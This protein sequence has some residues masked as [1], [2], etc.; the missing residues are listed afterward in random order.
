MK[1]FSP[2]CSGSGSPARGRQ[3]VVITRTPSLGS[4]EH[5]SGPANASNISISASP[6]A[7]G[8]PH[9]IIL[10]QL[11]RLG[12]R[13]GGLQITQGE[14]TDSMLMLHCHDGARG[15]VQEDDGQR[16]NPSTLMNRPA[17]IFFHGGGKREDQVLLQ[18]GKPGP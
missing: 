9:G 5:R 6:L 15:L 4:R 3:Y 16:A 11:P 2:G 8:G 14:F 17:L 7:I 12:I 1:S 18:E 10:H 13:L